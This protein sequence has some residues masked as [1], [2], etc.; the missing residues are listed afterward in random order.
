MNFSGIAE[1]PRFP[2]LTPAPTRL[3]NLSDSYEVGD[4]IAKGGFSEVFRAVHR[5]S[6]GPHAGPF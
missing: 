4:L 1:L 3:D 6:G 2:L 5:K